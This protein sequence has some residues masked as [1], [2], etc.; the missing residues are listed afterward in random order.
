MCPLRS[1]NCKPQGCNGQA[2]W[3]SFRW[4]SELKKENHLHSLF[5][6]NLEC[7]PTLEVLSILKFLSTPGF[8]NCPSSLEDSAVT[9]N[10]HCINSQ[11]NVKMLVDN[12]ELLNRL[13]DFIP[14]Q[15]VIFLWCL[16]HISLTNEKWKFLCL[17]LKKLIIIYLMYLYFNFF[18]RPRLT[19]ILS[20]KMIS[21]FSGVVSFSELSF[22]TR[23]HE[24]NCPQNLSYIYNIHTRVTHGSNNTARPAL[25]IVYCHC[26]VVQAQ[27]LHLSMRMS[28][29]LSYWI[30]NYS[31]MRAIR[32][33]L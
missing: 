9:D 21:T 4:C 29:S 8:G 11:V 16:S 20:K 27:W 23:V 18:H 24:I 12:V 10:G 33:P 15:W 3:N 17:C 31:L 22:N 32:Q 7:L 19:L 26:E 30:L 5:Q 2:C 13:I 25:R 28:N 6:T 14:I 1:A